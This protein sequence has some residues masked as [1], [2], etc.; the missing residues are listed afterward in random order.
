MMLAAGALAV[1]PLMLLAPAA[2]AAVNTAPST[3]PGTIN[4]MSWQDDQNNP[5]A[6]AALKPTL[7]CVWANDDGTYSAALGFDNRSGFTIEA[8]AGSYQN[9]IYIN[10]STPTADGQPSFFRPGVSTTE[11]TIDWNPLHGDN[12]NWSLDG[13]SLNFS[14]SSGPACEQHPVPIAGNALVWG[15]GGGA[16]VCALALWN[17]RSMRRKEWIRRLS[18]A[19]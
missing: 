17:R 13:T 5:G 16:A 7:S 14:S 11:F 9:A 3:T 19:A 12:V 2:D 15:I 4:C 6:C 8:D 1:G 18:Q 10:G